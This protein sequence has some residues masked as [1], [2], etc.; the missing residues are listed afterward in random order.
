MTD[1]QIER[2]YLFIMVNAENI[3]DEVITEILKENLS[4]LN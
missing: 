2:L 3:S 1:Q 4:K